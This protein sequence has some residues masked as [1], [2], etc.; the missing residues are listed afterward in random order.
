MGK[1]RCEIECDFGKGV[2]PLSEKDVR[3]A[4]NDYFG[5]MFPKKPSKGISVTTVHPL[6]E[7]SVEEIEKVLLNAVTFTVKDSYY[8]PPPT[9]CFLPTPELRKAVAQAIVDHLTGRGK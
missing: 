5:H 3:L 2:E 1:L 9:I 8:T 4:L 7:V 6:P